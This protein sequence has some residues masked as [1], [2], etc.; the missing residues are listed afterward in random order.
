MC[1]AHFSVYFTL[2]LPMT[3]SH[4]HSPSLTP[5]LSLTISHSLPLSHTSI[6]MGT[7]S[8]IFSEDF[9]PASMPDSPLMSSVRESHGEKENRM[10]NGENRNGENQFPRSKQPVDFIS[11]LNKELAQ[12]QQQRSNQKRGNEQYEQHVHEGQYGLKGDIIAE[13]NE[14]LKSV[15]REVR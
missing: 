7:S 12:Q 4:S 2:T 6:G 15:I 10:N 3:Y 1:D 14:R 5:S 9:G 8:P 13:E 11:N